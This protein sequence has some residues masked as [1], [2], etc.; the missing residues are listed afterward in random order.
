MESSRVWTWE[1]CKKLLLMVTLVYAFLLNLLAST[2]AELRNW[3]LRA[4]CHRT[5]KA[6][7]R[8]RSSALLRATAQHRCLFDCPQCIC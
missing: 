1:R 3:L 5:R 6:E 8:G 2:W 7:P 4:W